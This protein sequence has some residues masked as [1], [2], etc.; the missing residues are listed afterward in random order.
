VPTQTPHS[1]AIQPPTCRP[2]PAHP[3][4]PTALPASPLPSPTVQPPYLRECGAVGPLPCG[5]CPQGRTR[6][7]SPGTFPAGNSTP[8]RATGE[9]HCC[10]LLSQLVRACPP[11]ASHGHPSSPLSPAI[12]LPF[13]GPR[14]RA[15]CRPPLAARPKPLC[16]RE[17]GKCIAT[18][19]FPHPLTTIFPQ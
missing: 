9:G 15:S 12:L 13:G 8:D 3:D 4:E 19:V 11:L 17:R 7:S 5:S 1:G 18:I 6:R 2:K 16:E 14:R 10:W